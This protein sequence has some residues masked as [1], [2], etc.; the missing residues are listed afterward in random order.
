MNAREVF[1]KRL[2]QA[3]RASAREVQEE[4][5]RTHRF[6]SR[7]GQLERAIDVR[8]IG[9]KTAEVYIDNNLAPYGPF[10]HEGTRAHYIFPKEKKSL[11]WVPAG[12]NGFVFAKRV[13][14]RGTQPDQFLYEALDNSREAVRDIFSKAVNVSLNEI[15]RNVELG[16]KRTELHIKL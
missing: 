15:A 10:V 2:R 6:T 3:I 16:A 11:R 8:M 7:S 4:A 5:Q 1:E 12:G 13:F 14:H 9:D